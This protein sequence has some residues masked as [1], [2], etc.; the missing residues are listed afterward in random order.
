MARIAATRDASWYN[1][2]DT[3]TPKK[4]H[5]ATADGM[6][7]CSGAQLSDNVQPAE[8]VPEIQRCKRPGCKAL[9]AKLVGFNDALGC[10]SPRPLHF[11]E[12]DNYYFMQ[13]IDRPMC[14]GVWLDWE[15]NDNCK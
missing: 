9:W 11:V 4:Y 13:G 7:A 5:I 14:C 12:C 8:Q 3:R 15:P 2:P 6:A 10:I 1:Y